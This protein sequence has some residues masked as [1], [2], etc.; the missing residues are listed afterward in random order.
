MFSTGRGELGA[1]GGR[2]ASATSSSSEAASSATLSSLSRCRMAAISTAAPDVPRRRSSA[3]WRSRRACAK[4]WRS[5]PRLL[6]HERVRH[7]VRDVCGSLRVA[8]ARPDVD[9]AGDLVDRGAHLV[10]E[11][12]GGLARKLVGGLGQDLAAGEQRLDRR[13]PARHRVVVAAGQRTR[14]ALDHQPGG[15]VVRL[16]QDEREDQDGCGERDDD[17]R[18]QPPRAAKGRKEPGDLDRLV[19]CRVP[20][21][22]AR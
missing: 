10:L 20:Q 4:R 18:D 9:D 14:F 1:S 5:L 21:R 3:A 16:R 6:L 13:E 19:V 22:D 17:E 12:V 7:P 15:G 11:G 2:A 8:V